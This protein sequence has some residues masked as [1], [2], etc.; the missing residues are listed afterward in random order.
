MGEDGLHGMVIGENAQVGARTHVTSSVPPSVCI[1]GQQSFEATTSSS[2]KA[3]QHRPLGW[4]TFSSNVWHLVSR[5]LP[6]VACLHVALIAPY[7]ACLQLFFATQDYGPQYNEVSPTWGSMQA[8]LDRNAAVVLVATGAILFYLS[9]AGVIVAYKW[10]I[11]GRFRPH[12]SVVENNAYTEYHN[13]QVYS[14]WL[15]AHCIRQLQGTLLVNGALRMLGSSVPWSV[16][17]QT[18]TFYEPDLLN[19]GHGSVIDTCTLLGHKFEIRD[20]APTMVFASCTVGE[21]V[22]LQPGSL[23]WAEDMIPTGATLGAR[24]QIL[25]SAAPDH[26]QNEML[27]GVPATAVREMQQEPSSS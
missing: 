23:V 7:H 17:I 16:H 15:A 27:L 13:Y 6:A 19:I 26:R 25:S 1:F 14:W 24:S 3:A 22:V 4:T 12:T 5:R 9:L 20:G 8:P 10:A 2:S 18:N 11:F 21:S